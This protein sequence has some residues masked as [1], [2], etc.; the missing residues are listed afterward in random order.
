VPPPKRTSLRKLRDA[1]GGIID[2]A[3]V[4]VFSAGQSFTGEDVVEFQIHGSPAVISSV[5]T[6][7]GL[8]PGLR[9]AE[10]GEFSRR[11]LENDRLDLAQLEGL[12][13]LIEAETEA[14][15][16]QAMRIMS[17][18]L[19][20]RVQAWR[21]LLV[22]AMAL[23]EATI[24]FADEDVPVDVAPEVQ[25]LLG[26]LLVEFERELEGVKA[27]Q[28]IKDGFRVAIV[29]P[30]N[31]GK[32][33]LLNHLA[34]RE[35]A[36]TSEFAGTTRDVIEVQLDI[37]G[38][39]VIFL[40]TAGIRETSDEVEQI[41]IGR[42]RSAADE[43]DMRIYLIEDELSFVPQDVDSDLVFRAKDDDG[44]VAGISGKTGFGVS[45][46]IEHVAE[47]FEER[48]SAVGVAIKDRH[49]VALSSAAFAIRRALVSI[50]SGME[51]PE[52]V[53]EE[54]RAA[55]FSVESLVGHVDIEHILG[56]IFAKF[57][58]GK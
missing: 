45:R 25:D 18:A 22:R 9:H 3:L 29:G 14:Q 51:D 4:L 19:G 53:A 55:V 15:R 6:C 36:I 46:L 43:A 27:A 12:G 52:L 17:G 33:T 28:S 37:R 32:S 49:R 13:D 24:D 41:G 34:Q 10:A 38:M 8:M 47:V 56:E 21:T 26:R 2:E 16:A 7:L 23:V 39:P 11:A 42:A 31:V 20:D 40:D 54:L 48:A 50:E 30:P 44:R 58:I 57:C 1:E 35:V 5:L